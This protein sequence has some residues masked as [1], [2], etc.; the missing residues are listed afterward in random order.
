[1]SARSRCPECGGRNRIAETRAQLQ[2]LAAGAL[3]R[4]LIWTP[5]LAVLVI[6]FCLFS[7]TIA[8]V[9]VILAV[10]GVAVLAEDRARARGWLSPEWGLLTWLLNLFLTLSVFELYFALVLTGLFRLTRSLFP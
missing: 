1:M 7:L 10:L 6:T 9:L 4:G 3:V 8:P 5:I 2:A